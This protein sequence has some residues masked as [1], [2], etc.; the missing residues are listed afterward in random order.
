MHMHAYSI[1]R[2]QNQNFKL[3]LQARLSTDTNGVSTCLGLQAEAKVESGQIV[4]ALE[5]KI[6]PDN[7][8]TPV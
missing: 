3:E 6:S 5:A 4:T 7:L 2:Q 8:F 1:E